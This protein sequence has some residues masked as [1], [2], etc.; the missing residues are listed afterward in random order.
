MIAP[1][2]THAVV[3]PL[4]P[5]LETA[6]RNVFGFP[7]L[8]PGQEDVIRSVMDGHDTLAVMPTGAG[9][10]LCYQLPALQLDGMT[11][12]VSPLISLMRDQADKLTEAGIAT[13]VLNSALS[14]SEE[15]EAMDAIADRRRCA[16]CSSR[17]SGSSTRSSSA[18]LTATSMPEIAL[19]VIDEAH[20]ISQWGHDFRPAYRRA[21]SRDQSCWA[22]RRCSR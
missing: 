16:C 10:S 7:N 12:V 4:D 3:E 13:A 5:E 9:K 17:R 2:R 11:I 8:R 22:A 20:C 15:R 14:A 1:R 19:V 6:L 18:M 21:D